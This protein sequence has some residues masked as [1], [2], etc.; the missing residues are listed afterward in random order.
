MPGAL[1]GTRLKSMLVLVAPPNTIARV[2]WALMTWR[3]DYNASAAEAGCGKGQTYA[4]G[5]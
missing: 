2:A 3:E 1:A 5:Q 4:V